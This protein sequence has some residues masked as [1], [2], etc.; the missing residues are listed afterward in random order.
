ML[1]WVLGHSLRTQEVEGYA[2]GG[3]AGH[4]GTLYQNLCKAGFVSAML[5]NGPLALYLIG[6]LSAMEISPQPGRPLKES[7]FQL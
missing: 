2:V 5:E 6:K 3:Q 7:P 4:S 1:P